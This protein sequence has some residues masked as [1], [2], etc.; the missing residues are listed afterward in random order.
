[1]TKNIDTSGIAGHPKGLTTLFFTELW[2]RFSYYGMRAILILYM[3]APPTAG[4]LGFDIKTA[5]SVYGTYTMSVYLM[6]L[7]G[8]Y[9]ADRFL[10]TR[11]AVLIGAVVIAIGHVLLAI[12]SLWLFYG[13]L[14]MITVGTGLLKPNISAL[15]GSLYCENDTR[16]DAGFSIFFMGINAG[17][18]LAPII[19][20]FLAQSDDFKDVLAQ[21]GFNPHGSWHWGFGAAGVGMVLGLAQFLWHYKRFSHIGDKVYGLGDST[22]NNQLNNSNHNISQRLTPDEWRRISV[23]FILFAF[24]VVFGVVSEQAGSSLSLFA[25]R[26]TRTEIWGWKFPSSWFQSVV[27]LYVILLSPIISLLWG[28]MG[29]RQPSSPAKFSLSLL[30]VGLAYMLMVPASLA[31]GSG[32][33]SSFWLL[34]VFFLQEIGAVLL[35]PTG[36][37]VV[38]K[39]APLRLAGVMMGVWFLASAVASRIAGYLAGF[40]DEKNTLF[41]AQYFG[42]LAVVMLAA[43]GVLALLTPAIRRLMGGVR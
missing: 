21:A 1:M 18:A 36:L 40:F 19:C 32:D 4:G 41:L 25:D 34:G 16:R 30:F 6:A 33:V 23:V 26:L 31:A 37:S 20:G 17:A 42:T 35:N 22:L 13:G 14:V 11:I 12:S 7:P 43:A 28:R 9:I 10:G 8:G 24:T 29:T 5:A 15:V 38:T 39:L 2:E 27:P 3:V